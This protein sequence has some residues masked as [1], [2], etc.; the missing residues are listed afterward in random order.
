MEEIDKEWS[1]HKL[2]VYGKA[3]VINTLLMASVNYRISVNPISDRCR[4]EIELYLGHKKKHRVAWKKL[5]QTK[6]NGGIGL[7]DPDCV[8]DAGK[9]YDN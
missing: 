5:I 8:F 3:L 7:K 2:G 4:R 9:K 6:E 1:K